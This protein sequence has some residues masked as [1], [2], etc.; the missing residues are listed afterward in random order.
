MGQQSGMDADTLQALRELKVLCV[1]DDPVALEQTAALLRRIGAETVQAEDGEQGLEAFRSQAPDLVIVD[2]LM[3]GMDGL[4]L[5]RAIRAL[6]PDV[7]IFVATGVDEPDLIV[8]ALEQNVDHLLLKPLL[9]DALLA[10]VLKTLRVLALRRRLQDAALALRQVLDA[11]P[12]FVLVVKDGEISYVNRRLCAFL[13]FASHDEMR[14]AGRD[15]GDFITELDG[16]PYGRES[17][18]WLRS[19]LEDPLDRERHLKLA[20]PR[21]PTARAR[22]F[23]AASS[24]FGDP[25]GHLL[26]LADV[27]ELEETRQCLEDQAA[28]DP[29]TGACNRR[30]FLELLSMEEGRAA[31]DRGPFALVMFDIDHFKS[32]NDTYGHDVGDSVLK[33]LVG[34]VQDCVRATDSLA[35]LGGEEFVILAAGSGLKRA[36]RVAER[37]RRTVAGHDF[38]GVSRQV[39]CSFGVAESRAGEGRDLL[40]KRVDQALYRAKSGGRNR[41]DLG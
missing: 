38:A 18:E 13:G 2:L 41:V 10:A 14:A 9:P 5:S 33:E 28:T 17:R 29:L 16:E 15:V 37:L 19:I 1:D 35:R 4:A 26:T 34:M 8:R 11:Y 25:G 27:S 23:S 12:N 39:T 32:I 36:A 7:P 6:D 3:P 31:S 24:P 22:T 21:N 40:L 30:R 20:D